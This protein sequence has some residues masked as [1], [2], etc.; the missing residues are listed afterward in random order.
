MLQSGSNVQGFGV[1]PAD[2]SAASPQAEALGE[3]EAAAREATAAQEARAAGAE[4]A[5]AA[6]KEEAAAQA[7]RLAHLEGEFLALQEMMGEVRALGRVLCTAISAYGTA[8]SHA[9]APWAVTTAL[10]APE[11]AVRNPLP[12]RLSSQGEQRD[13][14]GRLLSR[15]SAL[16]C[17]AAA[18]EATRRQLHN[19]MV[20][21]RGN[22]S[23]LT[24]QGCKT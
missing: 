5:L 21:L 22:V 23:P 19:Q 12:L 24:A 18:A 14:V 20:E 6:A 4:E 17:A 7:S 9:H 13:M 3:S 10:S 2:V 8:Q 11:L 15:I 16:Q 1:Q